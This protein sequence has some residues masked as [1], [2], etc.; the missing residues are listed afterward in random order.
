MG[1][2]RIAGMHGYHP[3]EAD[4]AAMICSNQPMPENLSRI[5]HIHGLMRPFA[6]RRI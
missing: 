1:A 3:D 6:H 2:K 5:E 4:A